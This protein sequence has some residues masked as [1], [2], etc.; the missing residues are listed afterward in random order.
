MTIN[1]PA[2]HKPARWRP[3]AAVLAVATPCTP[4]RT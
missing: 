3:T 1:R 2:S 4:E